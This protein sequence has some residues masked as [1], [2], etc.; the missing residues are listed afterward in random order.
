MKEFLFPVFL[1]VSSTPLM[2]DPIPLLS[3]LSSPCSSAPQPT[4]NHASF[5]AYFFLLF[6]PP[7]PSPPL[8]SSPLLPPGPSLAV[9]I[10][11]VKQGLQ[12]SV[13]SV[14]VRLGVVEAISVVAVDTV[15]WAPVLVDHV[16]SLVQHLRGESRRRWREAPARL[17]LLPGGGGPGF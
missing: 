16:Q 6:S 11:H 15:L 17:R 8:L 13:V 3:L 7:L 9:V 1:L 4:H 5:L 14:P 12:Q 2:P 10:Y